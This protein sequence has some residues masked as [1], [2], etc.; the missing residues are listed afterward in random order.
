MSVTVYLYDD[1][2]SHTK[3][4]LRRLARLLEQIMADT[5]L[6]TAVPRKQL[7]ASQVEH[8]P[9]VEPFRH[10]RLP[11]RLLEVRPDLLFARVH[12][13]Q[14]VLTRLGVMLATDPPLRFQLQV[15]LEKEEEIRGRHCPAGEEVIGHPSA[16]EIVGR[17][18]VGENVDEELA[19]RFEEGRDFGNELFVVFH[20]FEQFD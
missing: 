4:A 13:R 18:L 12:L 16:L 5:P 14:P 8:L 10:I 9:A 3:L 19:G 1:F 15:S 6:L 17:T 11:I 2:E 7:R 20:V